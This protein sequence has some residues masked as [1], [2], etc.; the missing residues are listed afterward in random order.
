MDPTILYGRTRGLN[1]QTKELE[2]RQVQF[3]VE[4]PED[5]KNTAMRAAARFTKPTQPLRC[6][7]K[8]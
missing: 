8:A 6:M 3:T 4:V 5:E 1:I 2:H 7:K